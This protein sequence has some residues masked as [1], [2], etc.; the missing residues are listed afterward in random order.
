MA[1]SKKGIFFTFAAIALSLVIMITFGTYTRYELKD[2]VKN[3][4]TRIDS[5]N[6]FI[7]NFENDIDN[8]IFITGF[9]SLLSVEDYIMEQNKFFSQEEMPT[10]NDAFEE[11]F[12]SGKINSERMSLMGYNNFFNW[13]NNISLE[14]NKT[15]IALEFTV[16]DVAVT[17]TEPWMVDISVDLTVNVKDNKNTASWTINKVYTRKLNITGFVD[18]LYLVNNQGK[19]NNTIRRTI[20][21]DFHDE[22]D[23]ETH[24]LDSY[25]IEHSDAPNYLMRFEND[26]TSSVNGIE[27]LVNSQKIEDAGLPTETRSA[28]DFIYFGTQIVTDCRVKK[29]NY[30]WFRLDK[31]APWDHLE[32]YEAKCK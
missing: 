27:S 30:Q 2:E 11:V 14:A 25:Y 12:E 26:L 5:I 13:T 8:A 9:R 4:E 18:P 21:Q 29:P 16:N 10:L 7:K 15:D 19:V 32:F 31:N 23:L 24:L 22:D 20:V 17:Q 3:L 28:V 1:I 6:N